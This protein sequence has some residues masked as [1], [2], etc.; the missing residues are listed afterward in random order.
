MLRGWKRGL[1]TVVI[2]AGTTVC[3]DA[4]YSVLH[5]GDGEREK[6]PTLSPGEDQMNHCAE[7]G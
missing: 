7:V 6:N 4:R 1:G 5:S 3:D 2:S